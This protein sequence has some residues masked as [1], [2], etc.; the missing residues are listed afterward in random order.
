MSRLI[1]G[2]SKSKSISSSDV[3]RHAIKST[4]VEQRE[5]TSST[6]KDGKPRNFK[7][8][9]YLGSQRVVNLI[10]ARNAACAILWALNFMASR[11]FNCTPRFKTSTTEATLKVIGMSVYSSSFDHRCSVDIIPLK[12]SII[13][14]KTKS[15]GSTI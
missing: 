2:L 12:P 10:H 4:T 8:I 1:R 6:R 14:G 3:Y 15:S 7:V 13:G 11:G 9:A 5:Q